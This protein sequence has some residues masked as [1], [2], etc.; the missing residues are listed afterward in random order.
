MEGSYEEERYYL[1]NLIGESME[2][3]LQLL[4]ESLVRKIKVLDKI[5]EFDLKQKDVLSSDDATPD[6][7]KFDS[8]IEEK[9]K[10]IDELNSLDDGFE[11]LYERVA[12]TL[13]SDIPGNASKIRKLQELIREITDKSVEIQKQE[14]ENKALVE[15]YFRSARGGIGKGRNSLNAAY[16]Y[17]QAQR[18][19]SGADSLYVDSKQ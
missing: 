10:L 2:D 15:K 8:Y 6:F 17:F 18:G 12:D 7:E 5:E 13:K 11:A 4:E 16:S 3:Y 14:A 1:E 9:G 19:I